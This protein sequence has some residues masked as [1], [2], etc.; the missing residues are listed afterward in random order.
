MEAILL[1]IVQGF[2]EFLPISSSAHLVLIPSLFQMPLPDLSLIGSVHLGTLLAVMIYFRNDLWLIVV[3]MGQG[4]RLRQPLAAPDSRLGWYILLGS[5]PAATAG[6][7]LG[8][9]FERTFSRPQAAAGF[10]LVTAVLLVTGERMLSGKKQVGQVSW[11]D[12][13]VI[14]LFQALA[15]F[16]G[17]SRSGS[18]MT[19]GLWRGLDRPTTARFSFLLGIPITLGA[20]LATTLNMFAA[21]AKPVHAA[22]LI[23]GFLTAGISGYFCIHFLLT[24]LRRHS[25]YLFAGYCA[26]F[27]VLYLWLAGAG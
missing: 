22:V 25:F 14:G 15:L 21:S 26:A 27:G 1:G 3:A 7:L 9:F 13:L 4:I 20:G 24:W 5:V 18:T 17:I 2:T 6:L 12:A 19:A 11:P 10:L 8:P 23:V 16:P